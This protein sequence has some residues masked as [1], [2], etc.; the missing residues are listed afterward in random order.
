MSAKVIP[1]NYTDV[2]VYEGS[3]KKFANEITF[4]S[5]FDKFYFF[6]IMT[7]LLFA[8]YSLFAYDIFKNVIWDVLFVSVLVV[9]FIILIW[10]GKKEK[11]FKKG[12]P[13]KRDTYEIEKVSVNNDGEMFIDAY[14]I[15]DNAKRYMY[16]FKF[17]ETV[18]F[19][20]RCFTLYEVDMNGYTTVHYCANRKRG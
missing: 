5:L 12:S 6:A 1:L 9:A 8:G 7:G 13:I 19:A 15:R 11:T 17:D 3:V 10:A 4:Y 20:K 18:Q 16:R 14:N 2:E